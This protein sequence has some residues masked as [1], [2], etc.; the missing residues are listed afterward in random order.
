MIIDNKMLMIIDK[1][2][3]ILNDSSFLE[4]GYNRKVKKTA[5]INGINKSF[6]IINIDKTARKIKSLTA[7][8]YSH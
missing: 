6:P 2:L 4:I 3:G 8:L 5:I 7:I 1:A